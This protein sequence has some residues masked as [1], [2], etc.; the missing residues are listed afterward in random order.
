MN[1]TRISYAACYV[2]ATRE[3]ARFEHAH[4]IGIENRTHFRHSIVR[5]LQSDIFYVIIII[6]AISHG[7]EFCGEF[8]GSYEFLM[9]HD[10]FDATYSK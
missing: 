5:F 9:R 8:A 7:G 6:I 10:T 2:N 4:V 1:V 3:N